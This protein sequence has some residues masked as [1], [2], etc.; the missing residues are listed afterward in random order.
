[1]L[2]DDVRQPKHEAESSTNDGEPA[3]P[4]RPALGA[5]TARAREEAEPFLVVA[6]ARATERTVVA[7][8]DVARHDQ[9]AE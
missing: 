3:T 7:F 1:V 5:A 8:R 6:I 2:K 9:S 4:V